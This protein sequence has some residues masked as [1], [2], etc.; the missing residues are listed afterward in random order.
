MKIVY[1]GLS[2]VKAE[3]LLKINGLNQI[4]ETN[5]T[6]PLKIILRQL[7]K[8]HIIYLLLLASVFSFIVGET[9][10]GV[11][12]CIVLL[13]IISGTFIQ[14]YKA[15]KAI[16]ALRGLISE[17]TVVIRDNHEQ[18]ITSISLVV[19]DYIVLRTGDKVPADCV[20]IEENELQLDES[21]L[22]GES[23]EKSK[24]SV[25]NNEIQ[26][27]ENL[28][29]MGTY[30]VR[31]SAIA[32]VINTGMKT[33]FGKISGMITD[34]EKTLPLQDKVNK[35]ATKMIRIAMVLAFSI[36]VILILQTKAYTQQALVDSLIFM[37][38]LAVSAFPEGLPVVMMTTLATGVT[39][40][41]K[42]NAIVNRMSII[43]T[44]GETTVVCSDKTGTITKG[45]MTVRRIIVD[46]NSVEITGSGYSDVGE[47]IYMGKP[48]DIKTNQQLKNLFRCALIC[49][50]SSISR[51]GSNSEYLVVGSKIEASLLFMAAKAKLFKDD[52]AFQKTL[53]NPFNSEKKQMS[54]Y[55]EIN[56]KKYLFVKGAPEVIINQC[57]KI[58]KKNELIDLTNS[59]KSKLLNETNELSNQAYH[60]LGFAY[61]SDNNK[62]NKDLTSNLVFLGITGME[63]PP[64]D[65]VADA[66]NACKNAG[67]AVKMITGD[68]QNTALSICKQIGL[69][70]NMLNGEDLDNLNDEE[71]K[72]IVQSITIFS[73]VRP[74]HKLRIVRTLKEMGE[75]VTMTGDGVND[76]PAL[77]EANIGVAMG[78]N[79]TDVSRSVADLIL[80]DDNFITIVEAIREGRTV[81]NNIRKFITYQLSCNYSELFILFFGVILSPVLGWQIPLFVSLQILFMNLVTDD[82]PAITLALNRSSKDAM[83]EPPRKNKEII[84]PS[85]YT[86]MFIAS[87]LMTF[88]VLFIYFISFNLFRLSS[89]TSRTI[90]LIMLI[91]LEI[92][93]A[94]NF[95]SFRFPTLTRSPLINMNLFWASIISLVATATIIYTPLNKIFAT[96]TVNGEMIL[97]TIF[98]VLIFLLL[99]DFLKHLNNHNK[100]LN[101]E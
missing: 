77:K 94:F 88:F 43:E 78:K 17:T 81:F 57:N 24:S 44:L 53:E 34:S 4:S 3:E 97:L 13:L 99:F 101:F 69:E 19:G 25:K 11:V 40:M 98:F 91:L 55:G 1:E 9:I 85:L 74:E 39:R 61:A 87:F 41:A 82:L 38:A 22:T 6:S 50:N 84:T 12:I 23:K 62:D 71:L 20:V 52:F 26:K 18:E 51:T 58:L 47:F 32:K 65:G 30:V 31:G 95:R 93:N 5:K 2:S 28:V 10:S 49:N 68:N 16:N 37:I 36:G 92:A 45:E 46:G 72:K 100:Y 75:I 96:E 89:D 73:R 8:D 48:I 90:A 54:V 15:D 7:R 70:G 64:R 59:E 33:K 67:I 66:I 60:M 79:G 56:K 86:A 14:E 83:Q 21:M 29:F 80:K 63:D 76:A 27:E 42:K 35:I